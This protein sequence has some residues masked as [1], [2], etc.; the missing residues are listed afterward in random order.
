MEEERRENLLKARERYC[1]LPHF[2][3]RYIELYFRIL[4]DV[5]F[6]IVQNFNP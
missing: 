6:L 1:V 4:F 5:F 2:I 3:L